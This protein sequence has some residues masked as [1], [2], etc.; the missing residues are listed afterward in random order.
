MSNRVAAH[1]DTAPLLDLIEQRFGLCF[2]DS[3]MDHLRAVRDHYREKREFLLAEHGEAGALASPDYAK[4]VM[5]SEAARM[6][7]L[8]EIKPRSKK[9]KN[10]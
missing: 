9:K 7:I 5:I 2:D 3:P 10:K 8:R 6:M 4:A 1:G